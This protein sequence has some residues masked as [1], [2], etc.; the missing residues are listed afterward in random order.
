MAVNVWNQL[1]RKRFA[2]KTV[3]SNDVYAAFLIGQKCLRRVHRNA[4]ADHTTPVREVTNRKLR[5]QHLHA[6]NLHEIKLCNLIDMMIVVSI[7][8]TINIVV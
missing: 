1:K 3:N 4:T 7:I 2:G 8:N 6:M 5:A